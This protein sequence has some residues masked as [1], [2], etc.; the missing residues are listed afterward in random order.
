MTKIFGFIG[1]KLIYIF[2]SLINFF[3]PATTYIHN[4]VPFYPLILISS[5]C[6]F[7]LATKLI[8]DIV[9]YSNSAE[10]KSNDQVK[11]YEVSDF[12]R[13]FQNF[14]IFF[15]IV[16]LVVL[17]LTS[18][19]L[20]N[21]I[22]FKILFIILSLVLTFLSSYLNKFGSIYRI[23]LSFIS[24]V[25]MYLLFIVVYIRQL[26][27]DPKNIIGNNII[28]ICPYL[29]SSILLL[30]FILVSEIAILV[31]K[32]M[33]ENAVKKVYFPI[34]SVVLSVLQIARIEQL[35]VQNIIFMT[36]MMKTMTISASYSFQINIG[37]W[38]K[39]LF[40][41]ISTIINIFVNLLFYDEVSD[42]FSSKVKN[43]LVGLF[44][45]TSTLLIIKSYY[46]GV[47]NK[48]TFQYILIFLFTIICS[49]LM[50]SVVLQRADEGAFKVPKINESQYK[51]DSA[52]LKKTTIISFVLMVIIIILMHLSYRF[53]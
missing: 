46:I 39:V 44:G 25:S 13:G 50:I 37:L 23:L 40:I 47:I 20:L 21:N 14:S 7:V 42:I 4:K 15:Y 52:Y 26:F 19:R 51:T 49:V 10:F 31:M 6:F 35:F 18:I 2:V 43:L 33:K 24:S 11:P 41:T 9:N 17:I 28:E 45:I 48:T 32:K 38:I 36:I 30:G 5:L 3:S 16:F 1:K 53:L 22:K 8:K 27:P 12:I 29:Y 34:V